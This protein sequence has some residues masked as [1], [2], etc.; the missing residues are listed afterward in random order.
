MFAK[1]W[2]ESGEAGGRSREEESQHFSVID[3]AE[4]KITVVQQ[5]LNKFWW[6]SGYPEVELSIGST[7]TNTS[8]SD[9]NIKVL[10]GEVE[11]EV[12]EQHSSNWYRHKT[13]RLVPKT[14]LAVVKVSKEVHRGWEYEISIEYYIIRRED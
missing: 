8:S 7:P 11:Q 12:V 5:L 4:D 14:S 9:Y 13:V 2:R 10:F 1:E 3:R 6:R